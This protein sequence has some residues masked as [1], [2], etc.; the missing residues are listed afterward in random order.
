MKYFILFLFLFMHC[1]V[2]TETNQNSFKQTPSAKPDDIFSQKFYEEEKEK[3]EKEKIFKTLDSLY[4]EEK[5]GID[6]PI[7]TEEKTYFMPMF[8]AFSSTKR[9]FGLAFESGNIFKQGEN[10]F[11]SFSTSKDGFKT[12]NK[13]SL[14]KKTFALNYSNLN[15]KQR[16][17][18]GGWSSLPEFFIA[19]DDKGKYNDTLL[20]EIYTKQDILSFSYQY[21]ISNLWQFSITPQYAYYFYQEHTLDTG[22]HNNITFSLGYTDDSDTNITMDALIKINHRKKEYILRNLSH[23]KQ[24]KMLDLSYTTGGT[25]TAGDYEIQKI[26]LGGAYIWE[27]KKHH[28]L[29]LFAKGEKAFKAPFSNQVESSDL[30]FGLG[31]YDRQQRGKSGFSF[32]VSFDYLLLKNQTGFLSFMPF[33]EQA[34]INS[35]ENIYNSHSGIGAILSYQLWRIYC[36]I[37]LNYT[38][39]LSDLSHH[40]GIKIGGGF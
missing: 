38:H 5:E 27:F 20:A 22:K 29:A 28:R 25:W 36:P 21:R 9:S 15:F 35:Q 14:G 40:F 3:L 6:I 2:L 17:Y 18:K 7:K 11:I 31:I 34:Y 13:F 30:L 1:I 8:F 24:S 16:F 10:F 19:D 39:N 37:S 33:Y 26:S 4:E 32:G 12:Q 23:I